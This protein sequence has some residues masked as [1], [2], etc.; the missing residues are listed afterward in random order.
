LVAIIF[1]FDSL[2]LSK[3][4]YLLPRILILIVILL[5]VAMMIEQVLS[6]RKIHS[7]VSVKTDNPVLP[8]TDFSNDEEFRTEFYQVGVFI[9]LAAGYILTI[10][11][12]GYFIVTPL[13]I[14]SSYLYLKA[15]EYYKIILIAVG[16]CVFVYLLFVIFLHLPVPMGI[17]S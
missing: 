8:D 13:Y 16:F 14:I 17:L 9:I 2:H 5:S 6:H 12:M 3:S 10:E 15:T 4:A 1:Y 11:W 7:S